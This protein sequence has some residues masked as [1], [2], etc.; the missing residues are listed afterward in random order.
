[1]W[2]RRLTGFLV[3]AL[4]PGA[5][6]PFVGRFGRG[7]FFCFVYLAILLSLPLSM[8]HG[9]LVLVALHVLAPLDLFVSSFFR[10]AQP[11]WGRSASGAATLAAI[12]F[13]SVTAVHALYL[14][15]FRVPSFAMLPTVEQD[16]QILVN[17]FNSAPSPG[18]LVVFRFPRDHKKT[19]VMR[20]IAV[21]GDTVAVRKGVIFLNG[22]PLEEHT[23][24]TRSWGSTSY[25]IAQATLPGGRTF[26][27]ARDPRRP[28]ARDFPDE[29]D[30]FVVPEGHLFVLGDNRDNSHDS[31]YWGSVAPGD[32]VGTVVFVVWS[33]SLGEAGRPL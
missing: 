27:I 20:T 10:L 33:G 19:F 29:G 14:R 23:V 2:G 15:P 18:D 17:R 9:L 7:L 21:G 16:E 31:R 22:Q 11:P 4:I 3:S 26:D 6:H 8:R 1:M 24:G 13:I 5:G 25:T 28:V 32:I 12:M 30:S